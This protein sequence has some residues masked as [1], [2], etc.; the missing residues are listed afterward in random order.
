VGQAFAAGSFGTA[1]AH[2]ETSLKPGI[3]VSERYDSNIWFAP[4]RLIPQGR[5]IS[6]FV[7]TVSP[8][9]QAIYKT[10][11]IDGRLTAAVGGSHFANNQDLDFISTNFNGYAN[12]DG[13]LGHY[14]RGAKLQFTEYFTYTPEPPAF[15]TGKSAPPGLDPTADAFNRG[16]RTF[17]ANTFSNV[18][19]ASGMYPMTRRLGIQADYAFSL[20]HFGNAF[21]PGTFFNTASHA[22]NAGPSYRLT[23]H[24]SV[25]LLFQATEATFSGNGSLSFRTRGFAAE[26]ARATPRWTARVS[27]GLTTV[28]PGGS[29]F[30]S[31]RVLVT[32]PHDRSTVVYLRLA[33]EVSPGFFVAA[34]AFVS[35]SVSLA[36]DRQIARLATLSVSANYAHNDLSPGSI[37]KLD[38][39]G[40]TAAVSYRFTRWL[41]SSLSYDYSNFDYRSG[42]SV[43]SFEPIQFHRQTVMLSFRA[44]FD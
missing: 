30:F 5:S 23:R 41:S 34:G 40:A 37:A 12:V 13:W 28:A 25:N 18:T 31:G 8:Q 14:I 42:G 27:G 15:L 16:L 44:V 7:T 4:A 2:A 32:T 20:L 24:D 19:T 22:I 21:V 9:V 29:A 6:D 10:Q 36:I 38:S 39:Y 43:P 17:R 1:P 26:Y 3:S 33:R 11:Q 35:N